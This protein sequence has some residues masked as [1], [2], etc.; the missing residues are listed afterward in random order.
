MY[1][2]LRRSTSPDAELL[3]FFQSAYE[4]GANLA[5]WDRASLNGPRSNLDH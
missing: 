2:E 1:D 5:G 4:A 3:E